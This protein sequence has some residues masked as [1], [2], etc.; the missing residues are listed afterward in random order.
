MNEILYNV[1]VI[2]A[3]VFC[4]GFLFALCGF[5]ARACE[6]LESWHELREANR[7]EA[8]KLNWL[9]QFEQRQKERNK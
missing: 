9:Y 3:M 4:F 6:R 5:G 2:L 1:M 7:R 8:Q